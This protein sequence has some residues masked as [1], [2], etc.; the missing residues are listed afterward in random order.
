MGRGSGQREGWPEVGKGL[1]GAPM[2]ELCRPLRGAAAVHVMGCPHQARGVA[3]RRSLPRRQRWRSHGARRSGCS[4]PAARRRPQSRCSP[5]RRPPARDASLERV[6]GAHAGTALGTPPEVAPG[7][8]FLARSRPDLGVFSAQSRRNARLE[9]DPLH[10]VALRRPAHRPA[11]LAGGAPCRRQRL[12]WRMRRRDVAHHLVL[13]RVRRRRAGRRCRRIDARS[14]VGRRVHVKPERN[15]VAS[16]AASRLS[17]ALWAEGAL[18]AHVAAEHAAALHLG[19]EVR[20]QLALGRRAA[21]GGAVVQR[22]HRAHARAVRVPAVRSDPR[23]AR[24][25]LVPGEE[26]RRL[27]APQLHAARVA[28]VL[29]G[30]AK[31]V[32]RGPHLRQRRRR[33]LGVGCHGWAAAGLVSWHVLPAAGAA[34]ALVAAHRALAARLGPG[35]VA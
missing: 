26:R 2:V 23:V 18:S 14:G 10:K 15:S 17:C 31:V 28:V 8:S 33:R 16:S 24:A 35:V 11:K 34:V 21:R 32:G 3:A 13:G 6:M 12:R 27:G 30:V 19:G 22:V 29:A 20:E 25:H 7:L 5:R 4:T 1:V 9:L